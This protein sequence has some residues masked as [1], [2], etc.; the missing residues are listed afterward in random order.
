[1]SNRIFFSVAGVAALFLS[2]CM[3]ERPE[4][5]WRKSG[6]TESAIKRDL[7]LAHAEAEKSYPDAKPFE[8][9]A[10]KPGEAEKMMEESRESVVHLWMTAHGWYYV[11]IK[12]NGQM[13][14]AEE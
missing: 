11:R 14:I 6:W 9:K 4:P 3:F 8:E 2:A 13:V 10:K 5:V 12:R 7:A 1:M